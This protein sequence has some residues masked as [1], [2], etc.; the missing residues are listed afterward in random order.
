MQNTPTEL[1]RDA[2]GMIAADRPT[3][4]Q[5]RQANLIAE[6]GEAFNAAIHATIRLNEIVRR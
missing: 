6:T 3:L 2:I 4:E 1:Y 5:I